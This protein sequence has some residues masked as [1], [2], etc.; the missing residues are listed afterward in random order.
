MPIK[1]RDYTLLTL[2]RFSAVFRKYYN[3]NRTSQRFLVEGGP[4]GRRLSE[5]V[6]TSPAPELVF[7]LSPTTFDCLERASE[8]RPFTPSLS[9]R[10]ARLPKTMEM[11]ELGREA[12][13]AIRRQ[14][15]AG[16]AFIAEDETLDDDS[17]S[18]VDE[19]GRWQCNLCTNS[20]S[21]PLTH[22]IAT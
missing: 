15:S 4:E 2:A 9:F 5:A 22:S 7:Q 16:S 11:A 18:A 21:L 20:S 6:P 12:R 19:D 3:G 17:K 14:N 1:C 10:G 8:S 13:P